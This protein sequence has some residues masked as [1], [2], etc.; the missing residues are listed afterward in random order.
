MSKAKKQKDNCKFV[1]DFMNYGSTLNQIFVM[2]AIGKLV[3]NIL[4]D[5]EAVRK[6]M[7]NNFV[8]PDAWIQCA[9]DWQKQYDENY[10]DF[11]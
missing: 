10:T 8:N 9:E 11:K 7:K 3:S 5:K 1:S 4:K 2:D 6:S